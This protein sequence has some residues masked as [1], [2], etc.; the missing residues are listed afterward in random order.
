MEDASYR[1]SR[2]AS[3][4][5]FAFL[6]AILMVSPWTVRNYYALG[7]FI[8]IRSNFGLELWIGNNPEAT[9]HTHITPNPDIPDS[10]FSRLHPY[11]SPNEQTR[12]ARLGELNYM[13]EKQ[14]LTLDWIQHNPNRFLILTLKRL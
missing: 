4:L 9:G 2:Y 6:I 11:L 14:K 10:P 5:V 7:G 1:L 8:P 12:L 13:K 3:R